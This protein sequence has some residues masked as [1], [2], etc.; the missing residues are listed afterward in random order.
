MA[1]SIPPI[2]ASLPGAPWLVAHRSMLGIH[3]P[4]RLTLNGQDYV[5]WQNTQGEIFALKNI[6]PHQQAPLSNGWICPEHNTVVCP[7]HTAAFNS[8]GQLC[9]EGKPEGSPLVEPLELVVKGDFIW[10]HGGHE[11]RLPIPEIHQKIAADY[12]WVGVAISRSVRGDLLSNILINYDY[13]HQNGVHRDVLRIKNNHVSHFEHSGYH[14]T[15]IQ[16][17]ERA[18]NS[19]QEL[20]SNPSLLLLPKEYEIH[21]EYE[22]PSTTVV[23][24]SLPT[25]KLVQI[26][27][28]YP[29]SQGHTRSIV[30]VFA[31]YKYSLL[32]AFNKSI[33]NG[34]A[35]V[36]EQDA[37]AIE[38]SYPRQKSKMRLP[39]EEILTYAEDLYHG[40]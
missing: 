30:L 15:V 8:R 13:N 16:G 33:L 31:Q 19:W 2:N 37:K 7:F 24:T 40:W 25:G 9:R 38:T 5:L 29:E 12:E 26:H 10:T 17:L 4:Y 28:F 14:A 32:K 21:L 11:P 22:F 3:Q 36:V 35:L 20:L 34:V 18:D 27:L 6:C 23:R 1:M 39:N